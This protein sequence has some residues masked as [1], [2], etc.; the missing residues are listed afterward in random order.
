MPIDGLVHYGDSYDNAFW[1][2]AGHMFFGDGDGHLVT[3]TTKGLD[4]IGHEL[5]HGV[6]QHEANRP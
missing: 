4:V 2:G 6:T 3:D 5:T 1:D